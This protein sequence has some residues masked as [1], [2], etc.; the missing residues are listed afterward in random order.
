MVRKK[1]PAPEN[2]TRAGAGCVKIYVEAK[3]S[4]DTLSVVIEGGI[5]IPAHIDKETD[6]L[7]SNLGLVPPEPG[8][9]CVEIKDRAKI[10]FLS[11]KHPYL[12]KCRIITDSDAHYLQD[13][14]EAGN[15]LCFKNDRPSRQ[16]ILDLLAGADL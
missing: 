9:T 12:K 2:S 3:S 14:S 4:Q 16:E 5:M 8:F 13:I 6:S 15:I 11:E 1:F 7:I 10:P